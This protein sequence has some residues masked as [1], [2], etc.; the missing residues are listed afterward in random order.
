MHFADTVTD[1]A[2]LAMAFGMV[3]RTACYHADQETRESDTD[4]T[5][6]LGLVAVVIAA[7]FYP[8]LNSGRVSL[9]ALVH[10]LP[11]AYAG[12]TPTLRIDAAGR[13]A[14]AAR[15]QSANARIEQEFGTRA[16]VLPALI[17]QYESGGTPEARFVWLVDKLLP[18]L[19]HQIDSCHGL[20][21]EGVTVTELRRILDAQWTDLAAKCG[22]EFPEVLALLAELNR[23]A[24]AALTAATD[25][26][27]AAPPPTPATRRP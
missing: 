10:D 22:S 5:V 12:D 19:V 27:T 4:H 15:E 7:E 20:I 17:S 18:K 24:V 1:L 23:R 2:R 6:M 16:P 9:H 8:L 13:A 11:E 14:K 26:P 21:E 3:D 25:G